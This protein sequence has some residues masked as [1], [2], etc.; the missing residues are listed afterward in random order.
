MTF[1]LPFLRPEL[2]TG[3]IGTGVLRAEGLGAVPRFVSGPALQV[4]DPQ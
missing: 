4:L 2:D 3:K 1:S